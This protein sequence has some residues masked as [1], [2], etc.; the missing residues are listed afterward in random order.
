MQPSWNALAHSD[1]AEGYFFSAWDWNN[2][3]RVSSPSG[4]GYYSNL[5]NF[6]GYSSSGNGLGITC[7]GTWY[8]PTVDYCP[9]CSGTRYHGESYP[10]DSANNG[11]WCYHVLPPILN[12]VRSA[13][14][15]YYYCPIGFALRNQ[16]D[17]AA[18]SCVS[19][20]PAHASGTP[21][22]CDAGYVFDASRTSCVS[23][24]PVASLKPLDPAVQPYEDGL[25]DMANET[26]ATR[27]GAA[28]I[29]RVA[30]A[31][32]LSPRITSGYR[33]PA[34][35]TH[36][37]EVYDQWQLLKNNN[38]AACADTKRKV[39][40]EFDHHDFAHQPG[41]TSRHESG[42]A[43]DIHL[44]DYTVADTIAAGCNMSRP[45]P[46]DRVHFESPR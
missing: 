27:D 23:T 11:P 44:S 42:R 3:W 5:P 34:Y 41:N 17:P 22:A 6:P 46:N 36:I 1:H 28:C 33:P 12:D 18:T 21:C 8:N 19:T 40:I 14:V 20:C 4:P 43:V 45:V 30:R 15:L 16:P 37:R 29:V 31:R 32:H 26:Q 13:G 9:G 7:F 39:E 38:D 25:I 2:H 24:C 35:Q 10:C